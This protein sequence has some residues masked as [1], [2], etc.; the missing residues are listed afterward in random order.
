MSQE[1]T[2]GSLF[3]GIGGFPLAAVEEISLED[4]LSINWNNTEYEVHEEP[5]LYAMPDN[6]EREII[7][8]FKKDWNVIV[9]KENLYYSIRFRD[10]TTYE[11]F[12]KNALQLAKP[13][14]VFMGD[15]LKV[16]HIYR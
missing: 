16:L 5:E 15:V 3:D 11:I 4:H 13:H 9:S 6:N 1:I 8:K 2:L 7:E 10:K 14:Y 12:K